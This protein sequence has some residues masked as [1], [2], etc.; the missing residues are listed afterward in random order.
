M[1]KICQAIYDLG[2]LRAEKYHHPL[3]GR[4]SGRS[5]TLNIGKYRAGD[6]PSTVAAWAEIDCRIGHIPGEKTQDVKQQVQDTIYDVAKSD[7][8][9][10][11]HPPEVEWFG[12]QAEPWEQDPDHPLVRSFKLCAERVLERPVDIIGSTACT[13][14]QH[15]TQFN[16][17]AINF[18]PKGACSHGLNEYVSISSVIKCTKTVA[19]FITDWCGAKAK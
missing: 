17:A 2:E 18:G 9:L 14:T 19:S 6:W 3:I 16:Q 10:K 15:A 4:S 1:N 11:E 7:E 8:W 12:L 5:C 13:D